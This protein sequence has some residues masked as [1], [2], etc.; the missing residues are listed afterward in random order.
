MI[1]RSVLGN[2]FQRLGVVI[3]PSL[4]ARLK[5][6]HPVVYSVVVLFSSLSLSSNSEN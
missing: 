3:L 1:D 6:V 4:Y 5:S 2:A